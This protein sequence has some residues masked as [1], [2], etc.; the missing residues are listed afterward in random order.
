MSPTTELAAL[1]PPGTI[2]ANPTVPEAV[3]CGGVIHSV[4]GDSPSFTPCNVNWP[5]GNV[6]TACTAFATAPCVSSVTST[7]NGC[8]TTTEGL[9][10]TRPIVAAKAN[11][12]MSD[13]KS[14][15]IGIRKY[16]TDDVC[17]VFILSNN[18]P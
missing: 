9:S 17:I 16:F 7:S 8:P 2:P 15:V 5:G 6:T 12:G 4:T 13:I 14:A 11:A 1:T 18:M 3:S 10:A